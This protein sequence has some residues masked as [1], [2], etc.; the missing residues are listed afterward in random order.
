MAAEIDLAAAPPATQ[1]HPAPAPGE[2]SGGSGAPAPL[3]KKKR[4]FRLVA[5]RGPA[6][7][8][9]EASPPRRRRL[10]SPLIRPILSIN[11]LALALLGGGLLYLDDYR[12]GLIQSEI[13]NL[14]TQ[15][16][17]VA[18]ALGEGGIDTAALDPP[19][20]QADASRQLVRRLVTTLNTRARL[21]GT[22]GEPIADT[23][24]LTGPGGVVQIQ[25][26]PAPQQGNAAMRAFVSVYDWLMAKLPDRRRYPAYHES[27]VPRASDYD[28]ARRALRGE[29]AAAVRQA[30]D[31]TLVI[32]V[33]IPVQRYKQ[34]LGALMLSRT[35]ADV[36]RAM[37]SVRFDILK[38]F[39]LALG[40]TV[41]LSFYLAGAIARPVRRLAA[42][43]D[44]LRRGQGRGM[45][46]I[47]DFTG[48][49]D[50]IGDLSAALREMTD[51]LWRRMDAIE[52]FAADV[53]HEIKN[54]LTSLRSAVET[55]SRVTDREQQKKLMAVIQDDVQRLDRLISDIS[56][57]SR[58]DAEM[59]RSETGPVD[60]AAMLKA[61]VDVHDA[62]AVAANP[63]ATRL[64]LD[65]PAS[66]AQQHLL[67]VPGID[68]RL[69]QVFRNLITNALSFSPA[70]GEIKMR[71]FREGRFVVATV[72]DDG[73]GIPEGKQR[74]IFDRFYSERPAGEKFGTHSGLGLSISQQIVDAHRGAIRAEN[75][76]GPDGE[77][78]G[79]RFIVRLPVD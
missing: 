42:A 53:A 64:R 60:I 29:A 38:I 77:V 10:V 20:L 22:D 32:S 69:A 78:R 33:A 55:V 2:Q 44:R 18:G 1:K 58:L 15:G 23:R 75:R 59:S 31:G 24:I 9:P 57:A 66:A 13:E 25:E 54:P 70:R 47:P 41:L 52:R 61:L 46:P 16:L 34:V 21:F 28:E 5:E 62:T 17:I 26:L 40:V 51:A 39:A 7:M 37:R 63:D 43:A 68:S 14:K 71:V 27:P 72:E 49:R 79:A 3:P 73:P 56:D 4:G 6:D 65:M 8:P 76:I 19:A 12:K 30:E 35:G 11:L 67:T 50:E 36:D 45:E 74:A 48:R